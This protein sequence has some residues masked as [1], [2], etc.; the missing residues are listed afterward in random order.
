MKRNKHLPYKDYFPQTSKT[1]ELKAW[2]Q[3]KDLDRFFLNS[4]NEFV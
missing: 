3:I 4:F 1:E 2:P